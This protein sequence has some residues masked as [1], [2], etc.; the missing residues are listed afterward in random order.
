[1]PTTSVNGTSPLFLISNSSVIVSPTCASTGPATVPVGN[2]RPT[3]AV[4]HELIASAKSRITLATYSAGNVDDI[5]DG[6]GRL[7]I[8]LA[9]IVSI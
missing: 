8:T 2:H 9:C 7:R 1:M 5:I 6:D 3:A 4:I